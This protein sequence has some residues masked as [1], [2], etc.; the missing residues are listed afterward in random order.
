MCAIPTQ[1]AVLKS[2][3]VV[4]A[5]TGEP[6]L[7]K[8]FK[9]V[10]CTT[11]PRWARTWA[12]THRAWAGLAAGTDSVQVYQAYVHVPTATPAAD[13]SHCCPAETPVMPHK[14]RPSLLHCPPPRT[15]VCCVRCAVHSLVYKAV[16]EAE[17]QPF[18]LQALQEARNSKGATDPNRPYAGVVGGWVGGR[19]AGLAVG[20]SS[21]SRGTG[22]W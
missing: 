15:T 18:L 2:M 17:Y 8:K 14:H 10:D 20:G 3:S 5:D 7:V 13:S 9:P 1:P 6:E 19:E 22:C 12:E 4:V 21:S 16:Q 11:N